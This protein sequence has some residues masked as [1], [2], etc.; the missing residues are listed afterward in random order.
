MSTFYNDDGS[1]STNAT[2]RPDY[3]AHPMV[4]S[5]AARA[6][7]AETRAKVAMAQHVRDVTRQY[8]EM[9][10]AIEQS[11]HLQSPMKP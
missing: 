5:E 10:S 11:H 6:L 9:L 2:R 1:I 4:V 8:L 3:A 7:L